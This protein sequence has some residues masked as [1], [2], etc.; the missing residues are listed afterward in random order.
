MLQ[1]LEGGAVLTTGIGRTRDVLATTPGCEGCGLLLSVVGST[2]AHPF[3]LPLRRRRQ[4]ALRLASTQRRQLAAAGLLTLVAL[5]NEVIPTNPLNTYLLDRRLNVQRFWRQ[6]THQPG[7]QPGREHPAIPV[8][9][10]DSTTT[11]PELG[12]T[13]AP[14]HTSRLAL[15]QVLQRTPVAQVPVVGLDVTFDQNR[16]GT[17][18]LAAEIRRQAGRRVIGGYAGQQSDPAQGSSGDT[19]LKGSVLATAGLQPRD[20]VVGTAAGGEGD[21]P[22]PL[23]LI[24]AISANTFAGSLAASGQGSLPA[25]RVLDWSLHWS[26]WIRLVTPADLATLKAPLLLV[27]TNGRLVNQAVDLFTAPATVQNALMWGDRPLW[28][29]ND[30]VV[31]GV[32]LQAVLI[33]SLNLQ[34]WLTPVSQTLCTLAGGGLGLLLAALIEARRRRLLAVGLITLVSCPL[35]WCLAI[36]PLWLVPLLLPLLALAAASFSRDD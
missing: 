18:L 4:L 32:L 26:P 13:P 20:L 5:V 19:W 29:V 27:G 14:D 36:G 28:T 2:G 9:L 21:K 1:E 16:P 24:A 17:A 22:V 3:H 11:L 12:V 25:D 31:P 35:A 30:H 33:Q 10:L 34:H 15:A 7:P 23:Q 8:L 6:L